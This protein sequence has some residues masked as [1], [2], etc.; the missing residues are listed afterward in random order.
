[1]SSR[2]S[3]CLLISNFYTSVGAVGVRSYKIVSSRRAKVNSLTI[4]INKRWHIVSFIDISPIAHN[5]P[6][7]FI[8]IQPLPR[9]S[10]QV[11]ELESL[12]KP[13]CPTKADEVMSVFRIQQS[14]GLGHA[15]PVS[16]M[17]DVAENRSFSPFIVPLETNTVGVGRDDQTI[18]I[19]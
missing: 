19:L 16:S 12:L 3:G 14:F 11:I 4:S 9:S 5:P 13:T 7:L 2:R 6:A 1:M 18:D 17:L 15:D 10:P 8:L